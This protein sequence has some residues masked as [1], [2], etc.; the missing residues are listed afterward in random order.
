MQK[1][2][3][4]DFCVPRKTPSGFR[5]LEIPP[6]EVNPRNLETGGNPE[7]G[8]R[9]ANP[10]DCGESSNPTNRTHMDELL[11][12]LTDARRALGYSETSNP[13]GSVRY[14]LPKPA[15]SVATL[16][17]RALDL[18][19]PPK[20]TGLH[21]VHAPR[22]EA[23]GRV[24][25][26]PAAVAQRSR[27]VTA[28][29]RLFVVEAATQPVQPAYIN[30]QA[31]NAPIAV[32]RRAGGRFTLVEAASLALT[33]DGDNLVPGTLPFHS[34][35]VDLDTMPAYGASF[36]LTRAQQHDY[37]DAEL[38]D[39]A[40]ASLAMGIGRA[41]DQ[42]LLAAIVAGT[43]AAF[44]LGAAA[45]KGFEFQELR[46]LVGTAGTGATIGQDGTLRA[47]GVV[48]ELTPDTTATVV[49][50]WNRAGVAVADDVR[51]I[52][53]RTGKNG[54]LRITAWANIEPMLPLAGCFW[55][56]SA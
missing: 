9:A 19:A 42:A 28:G 32:T 31:Q 43:P 48:A 25:K 10:G 40:L 50:A 30:G 5:L 27:A 46:A 22:G 4:F 36:T 17:L 23:A 20:P 56:V 24:T 11:N 34:E 12:L 21:L 55:T 54:D 51:V 52:A 2:A 26:L 13:D 33:P 16:S 45:A 14:V 15:A 47:G 1:S 35:V 7:R 37:N 6:E 3:W 49:G 44:T 38:A 39:A 18:P 29:A 8:N 41:C 53:E